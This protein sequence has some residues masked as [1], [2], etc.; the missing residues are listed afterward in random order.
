M[1]QNAKDGKSNNVQRI[2]LGYAERFLFKAP[3]AVK[4]LY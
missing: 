3:S 4:P 1:N 2:T